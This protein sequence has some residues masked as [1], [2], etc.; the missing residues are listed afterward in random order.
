MYDNHAK[1]YYQQLASRK[2]T[3]EAELGENLIWYNPENK[4]SC[5]ISLRK[6]VE[7][8]NRDRW[9]EYHEWMKDK[10]ELM[11]EVLGPIVKKLDTSVGAE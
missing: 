3:L 7:V 1:N 11:R 5:R 2:D 10:M 6:V 8:T 4:K 9:P